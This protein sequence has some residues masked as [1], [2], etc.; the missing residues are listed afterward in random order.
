[1]SAPLARTAL[2][3]V[4]AVMALA[5]A[6]YVETP[7]TA[8]A[9]ADVDA[10]SCGATAVPNTYCSFVNADNDIVIGPNSCNAV[11]ACLNLNDGVIEGQR[12]HQ[13]IVASVSYAAGSFNV[14]QVPEYAPIKSA[15]HEAGDFFFVAR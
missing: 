10:T 5:V 4:A 7:P 8:A 2:V 6:V 1:M 15:G 12:L 13:E 9:P 14:E 3:A 11:G